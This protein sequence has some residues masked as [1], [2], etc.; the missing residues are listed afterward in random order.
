MALRPGAPPVPASVETGAAAGEGRGPEA[1]TAA[2]PIAPAPTSPA[3]PASTG[4][5][6]GPGPAAPLVRAESNRLFA[7]SVP[8]PGS[9]EGILSLNA[10]PWA[11]VFVEGRRI[12]DTP[13]ELRLAAGRYR[14]RL[15]HPTL[16]E[17]EESIEVSPGARR[18]WEPA[19]GR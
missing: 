16:G 3:P 11:T 15:A 2:A 1:A 7:L 6:A 18:R 8:A 12:G 9:G 10:T 19:L 5:I 14:V 17:V 13:R 4:T